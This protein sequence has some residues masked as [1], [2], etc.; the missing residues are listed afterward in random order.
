MN[1]YAYG[2]GNPLLNVD[3][4]GQFALPLVP[5][6]IG[7]WRLYK[8]YR[9]AQALKKYKDAIRSTSNNEAGKDETCPTDVPDVDWSD[10]MQPPLG[11]D[12]EEW[13]W[14][15]PDAPGGARG[16]YVN[17]NNPDQSAH[18]DLNHPAPIGPHWDYTDRKIGGW[19][20]FRSGTVRKK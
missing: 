5:I 9:V 3:V 12:G 8:M 7:T 15:G 16:G 17:P 13:P 14:R 11:P 20:I 6:A 2:S 1:T 18:P 19:R 4:R 10:P